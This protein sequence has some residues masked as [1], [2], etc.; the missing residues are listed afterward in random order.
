MKMQFTAGIGA[1]KPTKSYAGDAGWDLYASDSVVVKPGEQKLVPTGISV[2]LPAGFFGR[3]VARSSTASRG[4][5]VLEGIIDNGWRGELFINV[6]N[7]SDKP[8]SIVKIDRVAQLL[9]HEIHPIEWS[10]CADLP[11]SERGTKGFGSTGL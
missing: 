9:I 1:T 10:I 4:L 11:S 6:Y 5:Q 7:I 2:A 8:V 3:I